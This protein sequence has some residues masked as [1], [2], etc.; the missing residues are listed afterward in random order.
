MY[1]IL[2]SS[3]SLSNAQVSQGAAPFP[4]MSFS[5]T[6]PLNDTRGITGPPPLRSLTVSDRE[7]RGG[8]GR[9]RERERERERGERREGGREKRR[10]EKRVREGI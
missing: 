8:R 2:G 7:R 4:E 5:N 6:Y 1:I 3:S 9:G 10:E